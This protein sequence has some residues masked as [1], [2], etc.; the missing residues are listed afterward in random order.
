VNTTVF[1]IIL[2]AV[3]INWVIYLGGLVR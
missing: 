1:A 2:A 3:F